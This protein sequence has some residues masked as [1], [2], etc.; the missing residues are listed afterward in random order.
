M[1]GH[2]VVLPH[3]FALTAMFESGEIL[4]LS[5]AR[6]RPPL[7]NLEF[8]NLTADLISEPAS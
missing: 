5:R 7:Y 6:R 1:G 3:E 2:G 8:S 4:T